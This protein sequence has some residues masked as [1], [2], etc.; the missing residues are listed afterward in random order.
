MEPTLKRDGTSSIPLALVCT[1]AS[2]LLGPGG[3]GAVDVT[4][5]PYLQ[6]AT[7][8]G[9]TIR[10]RTDEAVPSQV[11]YGPA[12]E[13]LIFEVADA[14]AT[15]EHVVSITGLTPGRR[16]F[17]AIGTGLE[18]LAGGDSEHTF[19]TAPSPGSRG[20]TR[21]WVLGDSGTADDDAAA[22]RD[23]F[24]SFSYGVAPDVWLMLG[25]NAYSNG[26]DEEYQEAVFE[27]YP[28]FLRRTVLW[29]SRGNHDE[30]EDTYHDIFTLPAAGEA[31]GIASGTESY[32]SFDHGNVHVV[33]LDS[34]GSGRSADGEMADWLRSDL[35][36]HDGDWVI[37][38]WHHPPYS[39]GSHDSDDE[40]NLVDMR[41]NIVPILEAA[42]ADRGL[43]GHSHGYERSVLIRGH[44]GD[45]DS[46][47]G[48]MKVDPGDGRDTG[49]GCFRKS[50]S[51]ATAG[52]GT[53]YAV[54]GCSGKVSG[55]S[56]DHPAMAFS[57]EELGSLVI[58]IDGPRLDARF[59]DDTGAV[60][61]EFTI[62]KAP[63]SSARFTPRDRGPRIVLSGPNPSPGTSLQY[64]LPAAGP[65]SL[66]IHE[67]SGRRVALLQH[68]V[69]G[70]GTHRVEW[71]GR[72][73]DGRRVPPGLYFAELRWAGERSVAKFVTLN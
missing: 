23:A 26:E 53:V 22:V 37:A 54:V 55:G 12:P 24:A 5:G 44:Y 4:R 59:I 43:T 56:L 70:S 34:E 46:F 62:C 18:K 21:L 33:C 45:S 64:T 73:D 38:Y 10:W 31:G 52:H 27:M 3:A 9:V 15:T 28:E 68:E 20:P 48:A 51:G 11:L 69:L 1:L 6:L 16:F 65:V 57:L 19:V 14:T 49:D 47:T 63:K 58:D 30:D 17:Y 72:D 35:A 8:S 67:V 71:D 36:T 2:A 66:S 40:D 25:D 60:R 7:T 13:A 39:K 50:P 29:P 61:D 42:G 41:E 32:Y